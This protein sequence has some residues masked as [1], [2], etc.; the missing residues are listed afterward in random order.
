MKT[1]KS[2]DTESLKF[3]YIVETATELFMRFGVKRVTVEEICQTAKISKMTFYKYFKNKI[4]LAEYIIFLMLDTSQKEFDQIINQDIPFEDKM[5]Q[6]I[7]FKI[8][9]AKQFSKEF[10]IDF[11]HL[12]DNIHQRMMEYSE[13]NQLLFIQLIEE[14]QKMGEV[15]KDV[16]INFINFMFNN[17]MELRE[18]DRFL[19]LFGNVENITS[20][21]LNFFFYGIMGKK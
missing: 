15:R 13:K 6:F 17:F 10:L 19:N 11:M 14:A 5:N 12:S 3:K 7:K 4:D 20:D 16:S 18:D 21:M 8:H 9:Y 2:S 1:P